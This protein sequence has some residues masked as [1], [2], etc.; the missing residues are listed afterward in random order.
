MALKDAAKKRSG[1]LRAKAKG[2]PLV[3]SHPTMDGPGSN[4][5][6]YNPPPDQKRFGFLKTFATV[7]GLRAKGAA[8]AQ[9]SQ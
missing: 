4:R 7:P 9:Q 1:S 8:Q 2:E 5:P 6:T 3:M